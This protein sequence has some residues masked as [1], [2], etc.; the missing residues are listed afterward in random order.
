MRY[1]IILVVAL[2]LTACGGSATPDP[3]IISQAVQATLTAMPSPTPQIIE[4]TRVVEVT[5]EVVKEVVVTATPTPAPTPTPTP[6]AIIALELG[7]VTHYTD[8]GKLCFVAE[9]TNIG[10]VPLESM[11]LTITLKDDA[12]TIIATESGFSEIEIVQP[13]QTI[14]VKVTFYQP[15][16]AEWSTFDARA[17]ADQAS[18]YFLELYDTTIEVTQSTLT[19]GDGY[20]TVVG[21]VRNAG[22]VPVEATHVVVGLYDADGN[23]VGVDNTYAEI[24]D[25]APGETSP[26]AVEYISVAAPPASHRVLAEA[27]IKQ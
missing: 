23:L 9:I 6:S 24:A 27:S 3:E 1:M 19:E 17:S 7:Q 13:G 14:P 11:K 15:P 4:V 21:E 8:S 16:D 25:L 2:L 20:Y 18:R 26:F 5:R 10:N 22:D 12:G